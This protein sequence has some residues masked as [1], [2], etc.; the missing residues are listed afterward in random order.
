MQKKNILWI[1]TTDKTLQ[2]WP[3]KSFEINLGQ[4]SKPEEVQRRWRSK[5]KVPPAGAGDFLRRRGIAEAAITKHA[6]GFY[7]N[8]DGENF[9]FVTVSFGGKA[10]V[11]H[12]GKKYALG[13]KSIM[14]APRGSAF[15]LKTSSSWDFL[16]LHLQSAE[17]DCALGESLRIIKNA[18]AAE[19]LLRIAQ[20]YASQA[21]SPARSPALLNCLAESLRLILKD[22]LSLPAEGKIEKAAAAH[23]KK[24]EAAPRAAI[25][26]KEF[27]KKHKTTVYELNKISRKISGANFAKS[28][29]KIRIN[30]A[31]NALQSGK[32]VRQSAELAGFPDPYSFSKIFKRETKIP[33]S[34]LQT[35]STKSVR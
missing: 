34:R 22:A 6:A 3:K 7:Q 18:P 19:D 16:W 4:S 27:A 28:Q 13:S 26:A 32:N 29:L 12:K 9:A 2:F 15:V 17:W 25:P 21:Y 10:T 35:H 14:V 11:E 8:R 20:T 23:F 24:I 33:P 1:K 31:I 30:A 5:I